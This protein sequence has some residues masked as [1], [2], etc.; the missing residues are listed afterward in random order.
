MFKIHEV[1]GKIRCLKC[2]VHYCF[3]FFVFVL[4]FV[5]VFFFFFFFVFFFCFV[6]FCLIRG[7]VKM[8]FSPLLIAFFD[9]LKEK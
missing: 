8:D 4:F 7:V 2:S 6:L 5:C 9:K 3:C 1:V